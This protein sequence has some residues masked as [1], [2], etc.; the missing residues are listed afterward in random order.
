MFGAWPILDDYVFQFFV[1]E[2]FGGA[3]PFGIGDFDEIGQDAERAEAVGGAVEEALYRFGGVGAV[4]QN[5]F[6]RF[7]AGFL[8]RERVAQ[9][10]QFLAGF[11]GALLAVLRFFFDAAAAVG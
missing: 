5:S 3:L 7:L 1:Q 10:V 11:D 8:L 2:F 9:G 6:E 4:R